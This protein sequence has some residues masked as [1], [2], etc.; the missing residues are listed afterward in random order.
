MIIIRWDLAQTEKVTCTARWP[1]SSWDT[2]RGR[3]GTNC[4]CTQAS[5]HRHPSK[6]SISSGLSAWPLQPRRTRLG[7]ALILVSSTTVAL[8]PSC[9]SAQ[10][11]SCHA[12]VAKGSGSVM[13][14]RDVM[15]LLHWLPACL[16]SLC[17]PPLGQTCVACHKWKDWLIMRVRN[18]ALRACRVEVCLLSRV[19][20]MLI[21]STGLC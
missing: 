16:A 9:P 12:G 10:D 11:S 15:L 5:K 1:R 8:Q 13:L 2:R 20:H 6:S 3:T 17:W 4:P 14:H 19:S 7:G 21:S 18:V